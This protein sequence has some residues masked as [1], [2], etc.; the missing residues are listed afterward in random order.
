VLELFR[1]LEIGEYQQENEKVVDRQRQFYQVAGEEQLGSRQT[2]L[3]QNK[4][5]E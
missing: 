1:D 5:V 4:G 3:V 2:E